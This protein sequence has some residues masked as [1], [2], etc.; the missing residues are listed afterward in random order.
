M[1]LLLLLLGFLVVIDVDEDGAGGPAAISSL[2][3]E[4]SSAIV[5]LM[6]A[7]RFAVVVR[8]EE[9]VWVLRWCWATMVFGG[10]V[11]QSA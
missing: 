1:L 4:A 3:V 10:S 11:S 7:S 8:R 5:S 9:R 6:R 2:R